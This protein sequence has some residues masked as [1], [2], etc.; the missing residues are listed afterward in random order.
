M[1]VLG[2]TN[3]PL[4]ALARQHGPRTSVVDQ[5]GTFTYDDLLQ[6]SARVASAL[7]AGREDLRE[8]RVAFLLTPGFS[9]VATQW[10]IWRAG[11]IAVPL[12]LNA[13]PPE[14]QYLIHDTGASTLVFGTAT[15]TVLERLAEVRGV[16]PISY[17]EL[18]A[19]PTVPLV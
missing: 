1:P 12:P 10:G 17:Q 6:E 8:Q 4:I 18:A 7:L 13:P 2:P 16:R 3:L 11:G 9:W 14:L 19:A 5:L 15:D